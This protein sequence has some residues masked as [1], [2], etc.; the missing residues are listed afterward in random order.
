VESPKRKEFTK[1]KQISTAGRLDTYYGLQSL[2][3]GAR[4]N[5]RAWAGYWEAVEKYNA[6]VAG[7][8]RVLNGRGG[9]GRS[10]HRLV[11]AGPREAIAYEHLPIALQGR[12]AS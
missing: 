12:T 3:L 1:G 8:I 10:G 2:F 9:D 4:E 7:R 5:R 11:A 6:E